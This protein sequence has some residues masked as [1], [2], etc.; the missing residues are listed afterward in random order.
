[1]TI[2]GLPGSGKTNFALYLAREIRKRYPGETNIIYTNY[3][4]KGIE[5]LDN[6]LIQVIII[7]DAIR[8]QGSYTFQRDRELVAD[9]FEI[10]HIFEK[11]RDKGVLIIMFITQRFYNLD[12]T[13]RNSPILAFK[14]LLMDKRDNDLIRNYVGNAYY[15]V[16]KEITKNIYLNHSDLDKAVITTSWGET[17]LMHDI[18]LI[19]NLKIKYYY[20]SSE[21]KGNGKLE[22]LK[23]L[24]EKDIKIILMR[25]E[26]KSLYEIGK[27]VNLHPSRVSKRLKRFKQT[28]QAILS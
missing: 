1:M 23:K 3:L 9:Y 13:F 22:M 17:F 14:S 20:I 24:D 21:E 25:L 10:R 26:G 8:F 16:L 2:V 7:D 6:R 18:P 11:K 15:E 19:K 28:L 5:L 27:E 12:P 4:R